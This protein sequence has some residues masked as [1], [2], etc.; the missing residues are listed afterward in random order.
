MFIISNFSDYF[1]YFALLDKLFLLLFHFHLF[2]N[3]PFSP[4]TNEYVVSTS[5]ILFKC[6]FCKCGT[7]FVLCNMSNPFF[8]IYLLDLIDE[9]FGISSKPSVSD[10]NF[11]YHIGCSG[12]L[13]NFL[14]L[15]LVREM[16]IIQEQ[17]WCM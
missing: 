13:R 17:T 3:I 15:R 4:K 1:T 12:T 5:K 11:K 7:Y 2:V 8:E 9:L 6:Y 16:R 14:V 10:T